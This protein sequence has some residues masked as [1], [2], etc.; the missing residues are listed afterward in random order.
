[1]RRAAAAVLAAA[2]IGANPA[3]AAP[4]PVCQD[5][6]LPDRL[7]AAPVAFV[8]NLVST[9][10]RDGDRYWR[11]DVDQRVKGPIGSVV[12]IRASMLTDAKGH[13]LLPENEVGV[14]AAFDGATIV[15]DSCGLTDPAA[16]LSVADADRGA[17]IKL[18]LGIGFLAAVLGLCVLR[19]RRGSRPSFPGLPNDPG[20]RAREARE[21]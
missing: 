14:L 1:M 15:T 20:A 12:D 13:S 21:R 10:K 2:L 17:A 8:G 9:A 11:F 19:I 7:E 18:V 3:S 16:L 6:P 5:I 4:A